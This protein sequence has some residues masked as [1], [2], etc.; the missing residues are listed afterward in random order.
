MEINSQ[1][2]KLDLDDEL[3]LHAKAIDLKFFVSTD[4]HSVSD[5]A[6]M[7]YGVGQARRGWLEK[8]DIINTYPYSK[9]NEFF[10]K[11]KH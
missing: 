3:I 10:K 1:P 4:S 8:K 7:R 9:L 6:S 5:L 2:S 11:L